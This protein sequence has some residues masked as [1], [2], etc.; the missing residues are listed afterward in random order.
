MR[1]AAS[2]GRDREPGPGP[3]RRGRPRP[4]R[5][6]VRPGTRARRC[7]PCIP[8]RRPRRR[9]GAG[10]GCPRSGR[11]HPCP[12]PE[13]R[14]NRRRTPACRVPGNTRCRRD[15]G[16]PPRR[17]IPPWW[18]GRNTPCCQHRGKTL[19]PA[20]PGRWMGGRKIPRQRS[21]PEQ[22]VLPVTRSDSGCNRARRQRSPPGAPPARVLPPG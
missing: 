22:R 3:R 12:P 15:P 21:V 4:P 17:R 9:R 19:P 13:R 5:R 16:I 14:H 1:R 20:A 8:C 11:I 18:P 10:T 7:T 2:V 6:W